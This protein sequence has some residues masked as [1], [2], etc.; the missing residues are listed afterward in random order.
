MECNLTLRAPN[1]NKSALYKKLVEVTQDPATALDLYYYT[2][3]QQFKE[4]YKP[5]EGDLDV[6]GEPRYESFS[7][8]SY[9]TDVDLAA[10]DLDNKSD[11]YKTL[12]TEIP[13]AITKLD[14][15]IAN[16]QF[17]K[18]PNKDKII[19]NLEAIKP[20]LSEGDL[21]SGIP[22]LFYTARKH[23]VAL[24]RAAINSTD[25][26][27]LK[28]MNNAA[29]SYKMVENIMDGIANDTNAEEL[30][31][32]QF[33]E[34][35]ASIRAS[36]ANIDNLYLVE[37][38]KFIIKEMHSNNPNWKREDIRKA[39]ASSERDTKYTEYLLESMIDNQDKL[40]AELAVLVMNQEHSQ[41]RIQIEF[42]GKLTKVVEELIKE[43]SSS[44]AEN[45]FSELL[46]E[47]KDGTT[48]ILD[49]TL[50][51]TE[52]KDPGADAQFAKVQNII[53]NKPKLAEFLQLYSDTIAE[54]DATLPNVAKLGTRIPTVLKSTL[55]R[56]QGKNLKDKASQVGDE[57]SKSL[58][59]SN[60][61]TEYGLITDGGG[62]PI[63][64]IPTYF[65][66]KYDSIDYKKAYEAKETELLNSG[67]SK[68]EAMEQAKLYAEVE[69]AKET[70]KLLTKDL[71]Y[72]LQKFHSMSINYAKK[73]EILDILEAGRDIIESNSRA[74]NKLNKG[75]KKMMKVDQYGN[76]TPL[77]TVGSESTTAKAFNT[78]LD[79]HVYGERQDDLGS[80][81]VLGAEI[82]TNKLWR[83]I[84]NK[85][86]LIQMSFNVLGA[87]TNAIVGE[88]NNILEVAASEFVSLKTYKK[89]SKMYFKN[90]GSILKDI[91]KR[92]QS[93]LVNQISE[94]YDFVGGY[95][96][97]NVRV[98]EGSLVKRLFKTDTLYF[99]SG[100]GE[101]MVQNRM[102]LAMLAEV[103]T[104][105]SKGNS[106]GDLL[107]AHKKGDHSV[108]VDE[109][110]IKNESGT[111]V[112]YNEAEKNRLN[113]K[114]QG[115]LRKI[116]G[117]YNP[118][119]AVAGKKDARFAMVL[120]FRDWAYEGLVRRFGNEQ[121]FTTLGEKNRTGFWKDGVK[122]VAELSTHVKRMQLQLLK[123]DW[124]KL[125][126]EERANVRR[127]VVELGSIAA[128]ASSMAI[129]S[130]VGKDADWDDDSMEGRMKHGAFN[131]L[132]YTN[133]RLFTEL[134]AFVN[135]VE[136]IRLARNPVA[137]NNLMESSA[138]LLMQLTNPF[139][140]REQGRHKDDYEIA[141]KA[142]K[143][144]PGYKSLEKLTPDGIK[145][146]TAF[147]NF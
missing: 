108:Q 14:S 39:L 73:N 112:K 5:Q 97:A 50:K 18:N 120:K 68:E 123:E 57:I 139:E 129:L 24:N 76:S 27:A 20:L 121:Q 58:T 83:Q 134:S 105:D 29:K 69:A 41:R 33:V 43:A 37:A 100:A 99:M 106:K 55:E 78:F 125:T 72:S 109:V 141:I 136:A 46:Y 137:A 88:Y 17:S 98:T 35:A 63:K 15:N 77:T 142:S 146:A 48:H 38:R 22:K 84:N 117:N 140:V 44:K 131:Y 51:N 21:T 9:M 11:M 52:G 1:G 61:D 66:Q 67:V 130:F 107:D 110:Y 25:V 28:N 93:S 90:S 12:L 30:F 70:S 101:H 143:F 26:H 4:A 124:Q 62:K 53:R 79:M 82:D 145:D 116:Q 87:T 135:P 32:K 8:K 114:I 138:D 133:N 127:M 16:L 115:V 6:N 56:A 147:Y 80:F 3:T 132:V 2:K 36:L 49:I 19:A 23:L 59:R 81:G 54:L 34:S 31:G 7:D 144:I 64:T 126:P 95:N 103:P 71:A 42:D 60:L 13:L 40:P 86:S 75:G 65:T 96:S 85:T 113:N 118:K 74:Y 102:G 45:V 92:T 47:K 119:T 10:T 89:A 104:F 94:H 91:G 128:L 122:V 111:L